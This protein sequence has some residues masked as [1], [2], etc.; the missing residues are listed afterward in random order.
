MRAVSGTLS[1][2]PAAIQRYGV[3]TPMSREVEEALS[4]D[5]TD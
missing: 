5:P 1:D 4:V 2:A 3:V